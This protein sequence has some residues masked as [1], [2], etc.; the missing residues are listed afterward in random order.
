MIEFGLT[1]VKKNFFFS[2][3]GYSK[4]VF[5][6][7]IGDRCSNISGLTTSVLTIK[8]EPMAGMHRGV[9]P[10]QEEKWQKFVFRKW[11]GLTE[12]PTQLLWEGL[13]F[14][15]S[16][17]LRLL[18]SL[19]SFQLAPLSPIIVLLDQNCY[20]FV[21]PEGEE[22]NCPKGVD[23][24]WNLG[25]SLELTTQPQSGSLGK[26]EL[27][28]SL[29][30]STTA[31]PPSQSSRGEITI[32]KE[33]DRI[34]YLERDQG[35]P[36]ESLSGQLCSQGVHWANLAPV[37]LLIDLLMEAPFHFYFIYFLAKHKD[38]LDSG[39]SIC[40]GWGWG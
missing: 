19:L 1:K 20:S 8:L 40:L 31:V 11:A 5:W 18:V 37:Q 23:W 38:K 32:E 14:C 34:L 17:F 12:Y 29:R 30:C 13:L 36:L 26:P 10:R 15:L 7:A 24:R 25:L 9:N 2:S 3:Y 6:V 39:K 27:S 22:R 16:F 4:H 28:P 35:P 21:G 33:V